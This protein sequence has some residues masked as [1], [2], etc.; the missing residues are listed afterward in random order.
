MKDNNYRMS[1]ILV[2]KL[3]VQRVLKST[4]L[5]KFVYPALQKLWRAYR[6]PQR[7][8]LLQKHGPAVIARMHKLLQDHGIRYYCDYGTLIGFERE[9]GFLAHDDD[10]D[11]SIVPESATPRDVLPLFMNAGYGFLHGFY[12]EG[13]VLEFS[14]MDVSGVSIDVFFPERTERK[15]VIHAY[16]P[17]WSPSHVYPNER[18]NT[19]IRYDFAEAAG[20]KTIVI[21]GTEVSVPENTDEVL[22]SEYGPWRVP[23]AKFDT[24]TDRVHREMPG[25]V[26]RVGKEVIMEGVEGE[27]E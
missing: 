27:S 10:I 5:G 14:L 3:V 21:A 18:A 7:R 26:F 19:L 6:I 22:T 13:R 8:R 15:G 23:D 2:V 12:Y 25:F 24:V 4:S 17:I 9:K 16:Q 1:P 20:I 11:I